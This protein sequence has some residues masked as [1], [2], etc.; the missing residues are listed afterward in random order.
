[1]AIVPQKPSEALFGNE[2]ADDFTKTKSIQKQCIEALEANA[3]PVVLPAVAVGDTPIDQLHK[4]NQALIAV[5][6]AKSIAFTLPDFGEQV[7]MVGDQQCV[8]V[9]S[10]TEKMDDK[11]FVL[12][13]KTAEAIFDALRTATYIE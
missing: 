10:G 7:K 4:T 12:E 3:V 8:Q 6:I 2:I 5:L 13:A 11:A 1:M 9:A